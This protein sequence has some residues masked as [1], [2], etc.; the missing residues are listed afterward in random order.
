MFRG[1]V[2]GA[3]TVNSRGN[4]T[5]DLMFSLENGTRV[6]TTFDRVIT[7]AGN[8]GDGNQLCCTR[9]RQMHGSPLNSF[10]W[11][12]ANTGKQG[13][14]MRRRVNRVVLRLTCDDQFRN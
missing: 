11:D 13:V 5:A 8:V 3:Y 12:M 1:R 9:A 10:S 2:E 6:E 14:P 4:V 7:E